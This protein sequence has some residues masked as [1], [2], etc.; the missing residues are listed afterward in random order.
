[1]PPLQP[2]VQELLVKGEGGQVPGLAAAV[3]LLQ[4]LVVAD[5]RVRAQV[6]ATAVGHDRP[7]AGTPPA[8]KPLQVERGAECPLVGMPGYLAITAAEVVRQLAVIA[9]V[10]ADAALFQIAPGAAP[11]P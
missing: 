4:Q 10:E 5:A 6:V 1:D 2:A 8:P 11:V 7:E 3:D 9:D